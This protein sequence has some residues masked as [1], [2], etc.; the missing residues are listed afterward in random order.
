MNAIFRLRH[1]APLLAAVLV[2]AALLAGQTVSVRAVIAAPKNSARVGSVLDRVDGVW[3]GLD[4]DFHVGLFAL[5]ASGTRG[6]LTPGAA[7]T[8]PKRDVGEMSLDGHYDFRPWLRFDLG[9][10]ARAFS[11]A[12]GYQR[13]DMMSA[14]A[15]ASRNLGTPAVRAFAGLAYL[16][17]VKVSGLERP[18]FALGSDVGIALQPEHFAIALQLDYR[19]ERFKFPGASARSEQFEAF[20]VS[21]GVRAQ[22]LGGRWRL[23]GNRT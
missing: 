15:T 3:A 2:P 1:L 6:R 8:A 20:T 18:T 22:R 14:G 7:G 19:I 9:Y 12:A 11:S 10:A 17:V 23:G 4:L 13:W 21:V 16:P 5:S